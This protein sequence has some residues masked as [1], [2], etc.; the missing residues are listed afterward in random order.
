MMRE[1]QP[2]LAWLKKEFTLSDADFKR[3]VQLHEAYLPQCA[4]RCRK[5]AEQNQ[6]L[7]AVLAKSSEVTP[8][9]QDLIAERARLRAA[10]ETEMLKHFVQVSRTMPQQQGQRYLAWVER[11]TFLNS[12]GMEQRHHA[13]SQSDSMEMN[14]ATGMDHGSHH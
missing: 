5:I 4:E 13:G 2:E 9:V 3:V 11:E 12:Q 6:R 1:P 10:C 14:S 7:Q 8:E